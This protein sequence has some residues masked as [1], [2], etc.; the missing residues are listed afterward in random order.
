M[1]RVIVA[2]LG[3]SM[4]SVHFLITAWFIG[5]RWGRREEGRWVL[6]KYQ[7]NLKSSKW[8]VA[9]SVQCPSCNMTDNIKG[10]DCW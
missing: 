1:I 4:A 6:N 8:R 7:G 5:G 3:S 10:D 9:E 2:P